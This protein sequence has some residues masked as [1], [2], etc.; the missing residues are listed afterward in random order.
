M[1]HAC[2]TA[3]HLLFVVSTM[4]TS[5]RLAAQAVSTGDSDADSAYQ[6]HDWQKAEGL[7]TTLVKDKPENARFWYRLGVCERANRHFRPAL[8]AFAKAKEFGAGNGLP[9]FIADYGIAITY[10]AMGDQAHA[11]AAL[12]QSADGGYSQTDRIDGDAEWNALRTDS[13]FLK[14]AKQVK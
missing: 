13:Q 10:A 3:C 12:K 1:T 11:L 9:P 14:L 5:I 2:R 4:F 6:S 7:Y 8:E